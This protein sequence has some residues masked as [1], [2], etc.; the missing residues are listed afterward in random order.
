MKIEVF[1][2]DSCLRLFE[3]AIP[4]FLKLASSEGKPARSLIFYHVLTQP[5]GFAQLWPDKVGR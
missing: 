5:S 2:G 3:P 1:G 4:K